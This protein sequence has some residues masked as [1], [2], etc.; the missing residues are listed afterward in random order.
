MAQPESYV[1]VAMDINDAMSS[2]V[3][4]DEVARTAVGAST[5]AREK[6]QKARLRK[7]IVD[8]V[9]ASTAALKSLP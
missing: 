1:A 7:K 2:M 5:Q 8:D 6:K 9:Q 3:V 4:D